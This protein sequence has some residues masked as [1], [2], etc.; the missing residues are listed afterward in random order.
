MQMYVQTLR[1]AGEGRDPRQASERLLLRGYTERK[2]GSQ[3]G[4]N[5]SWVPASAGMTAVA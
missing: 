4:I 3:S 5:Q 1:H 2:A